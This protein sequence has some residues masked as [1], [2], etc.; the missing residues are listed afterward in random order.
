MA[1][2]KR[3]IKFSLSLSGQGTFSKLLKKSSKDMGGVTDSLKE[4]TK[5]SQNI[6]SYKKLGK[7]TFEINKKFRE[8]QSRIKALSREM[9]AARRP[10]A[11]LTQEFRQATSQG[12]KLKQ[13]YREQKQQLLSLRTELK[14]AGVDTKR[15]NAEQKKLEAGM[16]A[17]SKALGKSEKKN[18]RRES[19]RS[20][21]SSLLAAAGG[22]MSVRSIV[23]ASGDV[24]LAKGEVGSLGVSED[25]LNRIED[26][27]MKIS[28]SYNNLRTADIVR[29][30]YDLKSGV[31]SLGDAALAKTTGIAALTAKATKA[32]T[33]IM[34]TLFAQGYGIYQQ[35]FMEEQEK[36]NANWKNLTEDEKNIAFFENFSGSI[37]AAVQNFRTDGSKMSEAIGTLG[38][39]ATSAGISFEEQIAIL[40]MLQATAKGG[41]ESATMYKA[42]LRSAGGASKKLGL[43]FVDEAGKLKSS[44]NIIGQLRAK[45]GSTIEDSEQAEMKKAFGTDEAVAF[46]QLLIKQGEQLGAEKEKIAAAG[47]NGTAQSEAMA[48]ALDRGMSAN[49]TILTQ[50]FTNLGNIVGDTLSPI[51]TFLTG[52]TS[53][54]VL[55]LQEVATELPTVTSAL[56]GTATVA[57][58]IGGLYMAYKAVENIT[59]VNLPFGRKKKRGAKTRKG[60]GG[61][62]ENLGA[63]SATPVYV[64]NW[65]GSFGGLEFDTGGDSKK[66]KRGRG[67]SR[68]G[69][70]M[71]RRTAARGKSLMKGGKMMK[72]GRLLKMGKGLGKTALKKIPGLSIVAG[73]G[74]GLQRALKGDFKGGGLEVVSGL[75][76]T[77]PLVGTAASLALDGY[78]MHRDNAQES[79]MAD[80]LNKVAEKDS[81]KSAQ[82]V[83]KQDLKAEAGADA[84]AFKEVL[85]ESNAELI[86]LI[87]K[88]IR[89]DDVTQRRVSFGGAAIG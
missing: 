80:V 71:F 63:G 89:E 22:A 37:S 33:G 60:V 85:T 39:S 64:T 43:S 44:R 6:K 29:A 34:T 18:Q 45:Y 47:K 35:Q 49:L 70:G 15:L 11:K 27:A 7:S 42:F 19:L 76:S 88:V 40:G 62:I 4:M 14:G 50:Q 32:D 69:R 26:V 28:N 82:I 41:G 20:G 25:G 78:L 73:L 2:N 23:N 84:K 81:Q 16:K 38:A 55:V 59:G 53:K 57:A 58:T 17:T 9:R 86:E 48:K 12:K 24:E 31:A 65:P 87:K 61:I 52:I 83:I 10:S 54:L 21:A 75:A 8:N 74:F 67:R 1:E 3:D 68:K 36:V 30:A 77:L 13:T 46:V 56:V 66:K 72:A 5:V 79:Q 51:V